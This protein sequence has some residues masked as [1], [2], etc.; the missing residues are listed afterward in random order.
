MVVV[1]IPPPASVPQRDPTCR[2]GTF[3]RASVAANADPAL[4]KRRAWASRVAQDDQGSAEGCCRAQG[5]LNSRIGFVVDS[6][7]GSGRCRRSSFKK[8]G[9][10]EFPAALRD[11]LSVSGVARER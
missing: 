10:D 2:T 5:A 11:L 1:E 7:R 6:V 4:V 3:N 8:T 9:A